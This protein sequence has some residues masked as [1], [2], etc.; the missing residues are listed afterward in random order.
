MNRRLLAAL[1]L[2][3]A[4]AL[5]CV[6][7]NVYFP[8]AAIKDLSQKIEEEVARQ[9]A[10][11]ARQQGDAAPAAPAPAPPEP[12]RPP[13][14]ARLSLF[15][16]LF[17]VAY[18]ADDV[19]SPE[20]TSPAIRR[21]IESRGAR[22]QQVNAFKAQGVIGESRRGLLEARALDTLS[23]LKARAD[24]QRVVRA[25]N[26]DREELYKEIAAAKNVDLAQLERIR[27]T[28]AGTLRA[29]ARPGDWVQDPDGTWKQR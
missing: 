17:G 6:T 28:Y 1:V 21:I 15:D 19:P 8:E 22:L 5:A 18:A 10:E 2:F 26:A 16:Q 23:D 9:A 29:N 4:V 7:I 3:A 20:V 11:K 27:E 12:A 25:E 14:A 24:V 13:G